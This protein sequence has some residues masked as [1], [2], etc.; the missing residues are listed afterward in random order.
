GDAAHRQAAQ[1]LDRAVGVRAEATGVAEEPHALG[2]A[3]EGVGDGGL[4]CGVV[5]V[6]PAEQRHLAVDGG[7][8]QALHE[9]PSTQQV[10]QAEWPTGLPSS[11]S[12][13]T[14]PSRAPGSSMR[15]G[16]ANTPWLVRVREV[17]HWSLRL[18]SGVS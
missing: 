18:A 1:Q 2:A 12:A 14:S 11:V 6:R 13:S 17:P 3:S 5:V 8:D 15:M 16:H 9:K 10:W 4:E 7:V